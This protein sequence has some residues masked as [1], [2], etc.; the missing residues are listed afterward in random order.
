MHQ[1]LLLPVLFP[2]LCG[3]ALLILRPEGRRVRNVFLMTA[4]CLTSVLCA[5]MG[6]FMVTR[7]TA[8]AATPPPA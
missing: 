1:L 7:R 5:V 8:W 3:M 6:T 2:I 4:V